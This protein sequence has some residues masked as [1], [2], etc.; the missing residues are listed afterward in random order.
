MIAALVA[1]TSA[2]CAESKPATVSEDFKAAVNSM[3]SK[4]GGSSTPTFDALTCGSILDAPG[5]EQVAMWG[6]AQVP[7]GSADTLRSAG[8]AAGWQPQQ[9]KGFDLFLIGPNNIS[10]ALRGSKVRAE[11]AKC[12]ISGRHQEL[13]V[14]VRPELT[15]SQAAAMSA[16]F[17][18]AVVAARAIHQVIGKP[19]NTK[20]F[21]TS[22]KV[23]DA[24]ELSLST[25]G[26]KNGPR[27]ARWYGSAEHEL[28]ASIDPAT[29]KRKIID[30]LPS[31]LTVDERPGQPGYFQAT[32]PDAGLTVSISPKKQQDGSRVVQ[33]KLTASADCT[34]VTG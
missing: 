18:P 31:G 23:T 19:L 4:V 22:G 1:L 3:L 15:P 30:G 6:D 13:S 10:F 5:D 12:S 11:Q 20:E 9:A 32:T 7:E 27:G 21:P 16:E 34:P 28:D 25:C 29:L 8:I 2:G 17:G 33:F 14:D 24:P 26:E